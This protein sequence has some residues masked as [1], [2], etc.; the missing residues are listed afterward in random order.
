MGLHLLNHRRVTSQDALTNLEAKN[1]SAMGNSRKAFESLSEK[2][3]ILRYREGD[4]GIDE[5]AD[6]VYV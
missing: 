2:L 3:V 5:E 4:K 6:K 1:V